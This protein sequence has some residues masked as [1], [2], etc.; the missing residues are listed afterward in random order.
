M[1]FLITARSSTVVAGCGKST[2]IGAAAVLKV[3]IRENLDERKVCRL[4]II[5]GSR[6]KRHCENAA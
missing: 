6:K 5:E 3:D 2:S 1:S 4:L